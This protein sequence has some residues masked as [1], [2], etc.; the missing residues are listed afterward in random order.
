MASSASPE[1]QNQ[2]MKMAIDVNNDSNA[3]FYTQPF[4]TIPT[5]NY[6]F[7]SQQNSC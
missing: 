2:K 1:D 4:E 6:H 7:K 5:G 3:V